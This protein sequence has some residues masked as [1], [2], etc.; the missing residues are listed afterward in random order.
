MTREDWEKTQKRNRLPYLQQK[1]GEGHIIDF[2]PVR[3]HDTGRSC[4][5]NHGRCYFEAIR[6]M[7]FIGP[8][9]ERKAR[10]KIEQ[11]IAINQETCLFRSELLLLETSLETHKDSVIEGPLPHN[12]KIPGAARNECNFNLRLKAKTVP[13]QV[14]FHNLKSYDGHLL[15]QAMSRAKGEI[16]CTKTKVQRR[17]KKNAALEE[18]NIPLRTH[19]RI[20]KVQR[21]KAA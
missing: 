13:I 4:G 3:D 21:N 12:R 17:R 7:N 1:F 2:I 18:R 20:R 14:V 16:K 11:G 8:K 19:R 15:I 6:K 10:D 5:Q 9:R